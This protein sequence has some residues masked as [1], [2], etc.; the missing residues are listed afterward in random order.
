MMKFDIEYHLSS[1]EFG[2]EVAHN[3]KYLGLIILYLKI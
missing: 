1:F 3:F 2:S